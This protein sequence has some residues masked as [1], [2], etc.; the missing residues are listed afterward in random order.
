MRGEGIPTYGTI[1]ASINEDN[2]DDVSS[3]ASMQIEK[4][5][6]SVKVDDEM[7]KPLLLNI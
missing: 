7:R 3:R 2:F 6:S 1:N 4:V 5:K